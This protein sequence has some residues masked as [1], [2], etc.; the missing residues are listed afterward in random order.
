MLKSMFLWFVNSHFIEKSHL[1]HGFLMVSSGNEKSLWLYCRSLKRR[2]IQRD[3]M[4][5]NSTQT[6]EEHVSVSCLWR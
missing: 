2:V 5:C 4:G 6:S 3:I 1:F